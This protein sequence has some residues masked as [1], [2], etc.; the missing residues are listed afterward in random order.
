MQ[1]T[2]ALTARGRITRQ[3]YSSVYGLGFKS[4]RF[5]GCFCQDVLGILPMLFGGSYLI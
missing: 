4:F 5:W 3:G 2:S 1:R